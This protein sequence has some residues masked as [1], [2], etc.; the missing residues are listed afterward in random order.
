[1]GGALMTESPLWY[2]EFY[3]PV[4]NYVLLVRM[5]SLVEWVAP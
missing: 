4:W 3:F 1:M 5:Q 2:M